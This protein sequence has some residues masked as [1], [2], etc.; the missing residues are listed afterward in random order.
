M[1][2]RTLEATHDC[3]VLD[4]NDE[5]MMI[6]RICRSHA[7]SI[8]LFRGFG[9]SASLVPCRLL[10]NT[11]CERESTCAQGYGDVYGWPERESDEL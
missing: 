1:K 3:L 10:R 8:T 6:T 4:C 11:E 2:D 7:D 9:V 5:S